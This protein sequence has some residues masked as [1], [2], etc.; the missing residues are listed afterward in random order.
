MGDK[1]SI[2]S[3]SSWFNFMLP[4]HFWP[5]PLLF[6]HVVLTHT[7]DIHPLTLIPSQYK[8][9]S[10]LSGRLSLVCLASSYAGGNY[11]VNTLR[12]GTFVIIFNPMDLQIEEEYPHERVLEQKLLSQYCGCW[13]H[14]A[15]A[16]GHQQPQCWSTP[17]QTSRSLTHCSQG[18]IDSKASLP[19]EM[20]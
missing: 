20:I 11:I 15:K 14:G 2:I 9:H 4:W 19:L 6:S 10:S 7:H 8:V 16:P 17:N 18:Q 1:S 3:S 13:C 5:P 12:L